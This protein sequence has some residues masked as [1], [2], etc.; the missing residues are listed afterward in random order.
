MFCR[1]LVDQIRAN[2]TRL[3]TLEQPR[4]NRGRLLAQPGP[5]GEGRRT[6]LREQL[7][8]ALPSSSD[9]ETE[10]QPLPVI[11]QAP[12]VAQAPDVAQVPAVGQA[13]NQ[14]LAEA[15]GQALTV[16]QVPGIAQ[17]REL[18]RS[19]PGHATG[20]D[21]AGRACSSEKEEATVGNYKRKSQNIQ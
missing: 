14:A 9:D 18:C 10:V 12:A 11:V 21:S 3:I 17:A 1:T 7:A 20:P 16:D 8:A 4:F 19:G 2:E 5:C 6:G 13:P 15:V